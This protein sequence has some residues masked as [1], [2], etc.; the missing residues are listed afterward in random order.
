[1]ESV[2]VRDGV[3]R[4]QS[5]GLSGSELI[6]ELVRVILNMRNNVYSAQL[7]LWPPG[8]ILKRLAS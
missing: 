5:L 2:R 8:W 7:D 6:K 3:S 1:M 4:S